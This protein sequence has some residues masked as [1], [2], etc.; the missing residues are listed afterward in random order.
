M[1]PLILIGAV[2]A[3]GLGAFLGSKL[4]RAGFSGMSSGDKKLLENAKR[5]AAQAH[6]NE[7]PK[8]RICS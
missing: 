3:L 1:S 5:E 6:A 2:L 8:R 4:P 7:L